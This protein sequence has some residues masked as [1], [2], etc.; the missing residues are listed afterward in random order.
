MWSVAH[1]YL[2][3]KSR[4]KY[5]R[6]ETRGSLANTYDSKQLHPAG[7]IGGEEVVEREYFN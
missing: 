6:D 2:L 1:I 7:F 4:P 5:L 3:P